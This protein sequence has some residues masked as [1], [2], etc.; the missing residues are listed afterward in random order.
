MLNYAPAIAEAYYQQVPLL[1]ITAD[2]P[3]EWIGQLNNQAMQQ[4]NV[5]ANY[6]K[7][8]YILPVETVNSDDLWYA[9]RMVNEAFQKTMEG[10][11]GPVHINVPLKEPLYE[12]LPAVSNRIQI[13]KKEETINSLP[14]NST[15]LADWE[16]ANS[17]L[18][19]LRTIYT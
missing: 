9:H 14:G 8:G 11:F 2:R 5:F 7:A 12:S 10:N 13:I 15:F 16:N 3:P 18:I 17:I 4:N 1:I 6:I 19:Y